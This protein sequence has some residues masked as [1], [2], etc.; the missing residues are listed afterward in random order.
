MENANLVIKTKMVITVLVRLVLKMANA[1]Q[2]LA[3][4]DSVQL[5]IVRM[6]PIAMAIFASKTV[7]ALQ[8]LVYQ[9]YAHFVIAK[10]LVSTAMVTLVLMHQ[11]VPQITARVKNVLT[12][13]LVQLLVGCTSSWLYLLLLLEH[14]LLQLLFYVL[15]LKN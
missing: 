14:S 5:A 2:V 8:L 7:T 11:T 10:Y 15:N 9:T 4:T 3:I 12:F 6:V 13:L 1:Y